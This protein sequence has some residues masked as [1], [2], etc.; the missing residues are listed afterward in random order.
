ML[1]YN[2]MSQAEREAELGRLEAVYEGYQAE[3]LSLNM[4][5]GKP[6]NEQMNMTQALFFEAQAD[7]S[8]LS[9][10]GTDCRNYGGLTGLPEMRAIFAEMLGVPAETVMAMNNSSLELMFNVISYAMHTRRPGA[11]RP[12]GQL[13]CVKFL[14]PVPGYDRHFSVTEHFGFE[15]VP[16]PMLPDGPDMD[17]VEAL[18][19]DDESIKGIWC[20][21]QYT[22]PDGY[23]FSETVCRRL[24]SMTAAPD[25]LIMWD[26]TYGV[27]HLYADPE[28]QGRL[29]DMMALCAEAGYPDRVVLFAS[30]SKMTFAGSGIGALAASKANRDWYLDSYKFQTIGPDKINQ[31]YTVR[32]IRLAGGVQGLMRRHADVLRPKFERVLEVLEAELGGL[33]LADW[34]RPLGGYFISVNLLPGSAKQVV[35]MCKAAGVELT[36]AGATFPYLKDPQD[37][38][39][40][41]APSFP[42]ADELEKAIRIFCTCAKITALRQ[43]TA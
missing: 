29:P 30:T 13:E 4:A 14:C 19:R 26:N 22:N 9:D 37:R 21:P 24:A 39:I 2:D 16:V 32:M 40:R 1:S 15:L 12:W 6:S 27:H 23:V 18:C 38:N 34:H 41:I 17:A 28:K 42:A 36:G 31:L 8:L 3:K 25:F 7:Q 35:A 33:N 10:D 11:V 20:V 5:R 43:L